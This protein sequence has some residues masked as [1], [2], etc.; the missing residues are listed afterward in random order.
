MAN[1]GT[2][3]G[4]TISSTANLTGTL[5]VGGTL[6]IDSAYLLKNNGGT[7]ELRNTGDTAYEDFRALT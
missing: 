2:Y 5:T 7:L 3:N 1:A 4:Q 6:K